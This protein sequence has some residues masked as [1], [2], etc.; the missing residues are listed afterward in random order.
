MKMM[1]LLA[2]LEKADNVFMCVCV[3]MCKHIKKIMLVRYFT[4]SY[5]VKGSGS[6][7]EKDFIFA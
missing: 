6:S 3:C 7:V 1:L 5:G 4:L 2:A